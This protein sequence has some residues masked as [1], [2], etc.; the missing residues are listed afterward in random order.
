MRSHNGRTIN[1]LDNRYTDYMFGPKWGIIGICDPFDTLPVGSQIDS[2]DSWVK[3][4]ACQ[5]LVFTIRK[6]VFFLFHDPPEKPVPLLV[7]KV[8][9]GEELGTATQS[10]LNIIS[11]LFIHITGG[12]KGLKWPGDSGYTCQP[13]LFYEA[14]VRT[15]E[16]VSE[17]EDE[18]SCP[19]VKI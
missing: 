12:W 15:L 14:L 6:V 7:I 4:L 13:V 1:M 8:F 17:R 2:L 11:K 3:L 5:D 19:A 9:W 16:T 10:G 18:L